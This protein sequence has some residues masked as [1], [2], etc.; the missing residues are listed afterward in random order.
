[1]RQNLVDGQASRGITLGQAKDR[2]LRLR[3][4]ARPPHLK[5]CLGM[6][7]EQL[8]GQSGARLESPRSG[9]IVDFLEEPLGG[10]AEISNPKTHS[11]FHSFNLQV[12]FKQHRLFVEP[13]V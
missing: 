3:T 5:P 4:N 7:L 2:V 12:A 6:H 9:L 13:L 8:V 10:G 11:L 1:M